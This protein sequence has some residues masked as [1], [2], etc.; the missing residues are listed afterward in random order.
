MS[1]HTQILPAGQRLLFDRLA[2]D[3]PF[4]D[5][6]LAGGTALALQFGHRLSVD[7]AFFVAGAFEPKEIALKLRA[8]GRFELWAE[9]GNTLH[10]TLDDVRVS[11]LGYRY[12]LLEPLVHA[13]ALRLA[14]PRDIAGMELSAMAS[15]G[16]KK[17]FIDL[18]F[19]LKRFALP[20][21]LQDY[22]AKD[23]IEGLG[24]YQLLKSLTYFAEAEADPD[25]Q[26]LVPVS[27]DEVKA[28]LTAAA[29]TAAA[30]LG[31]AL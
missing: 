28:A 29:R 26:M 14:S 18:F 23:V 19:L 3:N 20:R 24:D 2:R 11:F 31:L 22:H 1:L 21:T 7:F 10:G 4:A 9:A 25:P 16:A 12:P 8:L 27:W 30:G 5:F 13:G 6:Y 15:R 17:D